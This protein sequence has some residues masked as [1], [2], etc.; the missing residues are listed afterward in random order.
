MRHARFAAWARSGSRSRDVAFG[1][2]KRG[3]PDQ[4]DP[5]GGHGERTALGNSFA[6]PRLHYARAPVKNRKNI[7][8]SVDLPAQFGFVKIV[9]LTHELYVNRDRRLP[10]SPEVADVLTRLMVGGLQPG[11]RPRF[12]YG[13]DC[14]VW[15]AQ[16]GPAVLIVVQ[17]VFNRVEK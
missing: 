13:I 10:S 1:R 16:P 11:L 2:Q 12:I 15:T 6:L 14:C 7:A 8:G 4:C 5:A 3:G 9:S 17:L